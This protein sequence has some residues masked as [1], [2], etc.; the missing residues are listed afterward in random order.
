VSHA[1]REETAVPTEQQLH[2]LA[3]YLAVV[4]GFV[5][6]AGFLQ[7]GGIY[8]SFMSGNSTQLGVSVSNLSADGLTAALVI[9]AFVVGVIAGSLVCTAAPIRR[10]PLVLTAVSLALFAGALLQMVGWKLPALAA[11][12]VAMGCVNTV[13]RAEDGPYNVGITYMTGNLVKFA[14]GLVGV[15][16]GRRQTFWPYLLLWLGL[17][18]GAAAGATVF[19]A[20]RLESLWIAAAAAAVLAFA[21]RDVKSVPTV[22]GSSARR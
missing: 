12:A 21:S 8:V 9:G 15:A 5:D 11:A 13:F 3:V 4:G 18:G 22:P 14:D 1:D 16:T 20:I 2:Y 10:K 17:I 19:R 6:A 7:L